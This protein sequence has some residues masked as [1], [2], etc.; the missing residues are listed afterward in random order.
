M[1]HFTYMIIGA[2]PAGLQMGYYLQQH[3]TSYVIFEQAD[4]AGRFFT[5]YPRHRKLLSINKIYT[6]Y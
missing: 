6:G 4:Q 2:G 3:G 5:T 1:E